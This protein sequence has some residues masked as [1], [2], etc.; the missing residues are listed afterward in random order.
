MLSFLDSKGKKKKKNVIVGFLNK[1]VMAC[2][3]KQKFSFNSLN[4]FVQ[5]QISPVP[6][7]PFKGVITHSQTLSPAVHLS[8]PSIFAATHCPILIPQQVHSHWDRIIDLSTQY[9]S[10]LFLCVCLCKCIVLVY[11]LVYVW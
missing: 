5:L 6:R 3:L 2:Y 9:V 1:I 4:L 8:K 11:L 7:W 10:R